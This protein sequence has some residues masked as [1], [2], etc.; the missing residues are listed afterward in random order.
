MNVFQFIHSLMRAM[1]NHT[2]MNPERRIERLKTFNRRLHTTAES[3]KV[4]TDWNMKLD[5]K[6]IEVQGR[7]LLPQKIVF[8]DNARLGFCNLKFRAVN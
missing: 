8:N 7:V 6:L 4:L 2:R 3:V 5:E 1:S